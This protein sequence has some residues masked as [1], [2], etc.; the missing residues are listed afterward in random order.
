M[1]EA[2]PVPVAVEWHVSQAG[3]LPTSGEYITLARFPDRENLYNGSEW[4]IRLEFAQDRSSPA[5]STWR[6]NASFLSP[7][8][9]HKWLTPGTVFEMLEGRRITARVTVLE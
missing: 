1:Q 7:E 4:S 6:G 9:P 5:L 8:G 3:K 2:K